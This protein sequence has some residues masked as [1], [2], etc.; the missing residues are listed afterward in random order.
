MTL[1]KIRSILIFIITVC[2]ILGVSAA[3]IAYGRGYRVNVNKNSL[4]PTGLI[5]ATSDPVGAQVLVDNQ[6]KTATNNSFAI[7]PG[8]YTVRIIKEAFIPW[9]KK[10]RVQGEVVTRADA[11]LFPTNPSLSPLTRTGM[12]QPT[13]SP[14]GS[15]IAYTIPLSIPQDGGVVSAGL[16]VYTLSDAPLGR[17]RGPELLAQSSPTFNLSTTTIVWSPDSTQILAIT[18]SRGRLYTVGNKNTFEEI[19]QYQRLLSVWQDEHT[20]INLEKLVPFKQGFIDIATSSARIL[21]VS[22]DETK[23]LYEATAAATIPTIINP[24]LIGTNP[25]EDVRT[26]E[27]KKLYVYDSRED[28][29]FFVL[30]QSELPTP[31]PKAGPTLPF[32]TQVSS[33]GWFPTSKHLLLTLLGKIDVMEYD[34]TNWTTIYAGPFTPGF[35]APWPNGSRLVIVTNLNPSAGTLPNLYTVNLR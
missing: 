12:E 8:W 15:K 26:I 34:R 29:N 13:L 1:P 24:P 9:E 18:G 27:P 31:T 30:D 25:T 20:T 21:A 5:S 4:T 32:Y 19:S 11:F 2:I 10:I 22:P 6:L 35:V 14:D 33:I 16:W 23:V 3:V 28:K 17:N 7:E